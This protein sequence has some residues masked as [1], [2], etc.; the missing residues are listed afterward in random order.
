MFRA[1]FYAR[2]STND[3]QTLPSPMIV[4]GHKG[5]LKVYSSPGRGTTFKVLFPASEV[6]PSR[7]ESGAQTQGDLRDTGTVLVIDD[8]EMV[9]RVAKSRVVDNRGHAT[10]GL[11]CR[12]WRDR[13]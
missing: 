1:G 13:L 10:L 7:I 8:E 5:A 9:C 11:A 12:E 3:Q 2:V 4:R 6:T